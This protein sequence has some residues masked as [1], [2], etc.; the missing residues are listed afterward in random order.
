MDRM[1]RLAL[2]AML[3]LVSLGMSAKKKSESYGKGV[4]RVYLFGVSQM[5]TDSIVYITSINEVDSLYLEHKTK[6]LPFRSVFSLQMK[7]YLEG[8]QRLAH[9]TSCVFYATKR[10]KISKKFYKIKKRFL[11]NP[12]TKIVMIDKE[13][14]QFRHPLDVAREE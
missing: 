4:S 11:D 6:F 5:L 12:W 2:M 10:R 8:K 13:H 14:F 9:Q 7:E 3:L 1:R